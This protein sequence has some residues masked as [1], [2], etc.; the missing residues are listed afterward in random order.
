MTNLADAYVA[1][2]ETGKEV[3]YLLHAKYN[4]AE[5]TW[6]VDD[7]TYRELVDAMHQAN[8]RAKRLQEEVDDHCC[9]LPTQNV[10]NISTKSNE[11][12]EE[13]IAKITAHL[14]YVGTKD[15]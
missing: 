8:K 15:V 7:E 12:A 1:S 13:I 3:K 2:Q 11:A 14:D 10:F 6:T 9:P 4:L 5:N